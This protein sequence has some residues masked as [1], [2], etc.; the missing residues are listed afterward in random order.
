M[1]PL[2]GGRRDPESDGARSRELVLAGEPVVLGD[3]YVVL[4]DLVVRYDQVA[5]P[6]GPG[7]AWDP[8]SEVAIHAV[9]V[10]TLRVEGEKARRDEVM[11]ERARLADPL[12]R[13]LSFAPVASG[14]RATL[15][16][17][18]VRAHDPDAPRTSEF[19]L[20]D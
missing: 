19:R 7:L 13:A 10:T 17:L 16:S 20:L 6:D 4:V 15:V 3:D 8:T 9:A 12:A 5:Q 18:E 11:G 1:V 2:F 14:F